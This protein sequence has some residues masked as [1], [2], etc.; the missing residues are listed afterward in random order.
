MGALQP[1]PQVLAGFP[2]PGKALTDPSALAV[3]TLGLPS[4]LISPEGDEFSE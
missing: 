4:P 2:V 1:T 3:T